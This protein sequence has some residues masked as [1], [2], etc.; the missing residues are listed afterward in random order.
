MLSKGLS[1]CWKE[2]LPGALPALLLPRTTTEQQIQVLRGGYNPLKRTGR[3]SLTMAKADGVTLFTLTSDPQ[4]SC[5]PLCQILKGLCYSPACCSVSQHLKSVQRTSQS[6]LGALHIMVG[7]L[8]IGIGSI[9]FTD[10]RISF[11]Q[12]QESGFAFW[13][14]GLFIMFGIMSILSEKFPSPCLVLLNVFLNIVGVSFAI[15]AIVLYSANISHIGVWW[16]CH[17]N[18][19]SDYDRPTL[20][21]REEI[22]MEKCVE[23]AT[24][25]QTLWRSINILL[26]VLSV[27]ELCVVISAAVL[28]IKALGCSKKTENQS[29]DD[30]EQYKSLLEEVTSD[31]VA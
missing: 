17:K 18:Y 16:I 10:G 29:L 28:G 31:P 25:V 11:W 7:L 21:P 1:V 26:I 22:F 3:M 24:L 6:V 2:G 20:S 9:L 19:Y 5:P 14:G 4:S 15:A 27:L 12:I 8:N 30:P 13:V 23:G